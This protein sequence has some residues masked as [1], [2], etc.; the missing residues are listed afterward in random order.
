MTQVFDEFSEQR[1]ATYEYFKTSRMTSLLS[2]KQRIKLL[3]YAQRIMF[4]KNLAK[5]IRQ[6]SITL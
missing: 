4:D 6:C 3:N 5:R 1:N 2:P